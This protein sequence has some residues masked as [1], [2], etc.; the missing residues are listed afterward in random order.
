MAIKKRSTRLVLL[1]PIIF[2]LP[3]PPTYEER[4]FIQQMNMKIQVRH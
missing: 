3:K 1:F 4:R 2:F